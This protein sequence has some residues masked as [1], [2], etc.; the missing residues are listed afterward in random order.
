MNKRDELIEKAA[1]FLAA[2]TYESGKP[3][4]AMW[5][6]DFALSLE[7]KDEW[8]QADDQC[9][10]L[11]SDGVVEFTWHNLGADNDCLVRGSVY[12]TEAEAN[13]ADRQRIARTA[14]HRWIEEKAERVD[15]N[16]IGQA[17]AFPFWCPRENKWVRDE[18]T[19]T[20]IPGWFFVGRD[21]YDRMMSENAQ[22]FDVLKEGM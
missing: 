13:L 2:I 17:K 3:S 15:W 21:D 7:A 12:R 9:W 4:I 8:P 6:A 20:M 10:C 11:D 14:I 5:M 1:E 16:N 19:A 18:T 22:H